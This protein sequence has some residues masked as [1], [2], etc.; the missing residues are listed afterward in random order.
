MQYLRWHAVCKRFGL[1]C[2][3]VALCSTSLVPDHAAS[4]CGKCD[5]SIN[6]LKD[7]YVMVVRNETQAVQSIMVR[8]QQTADIQHETHNTC[9]FWISLRTN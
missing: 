6:K 7:L 8:K 3:G 9:S 5:K 1:T 4:V 2:L